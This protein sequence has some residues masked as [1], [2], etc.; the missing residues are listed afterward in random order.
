MALV[1][2]VLV[3]DAV[4]L[5]PLLL[6][7]HNYRGSKQRNN[8]AENNQQAANKAVIPSDA[9]NSDKVGDIGHQTDETD[10]EK[11]KVNRQL[12]QYTKQLSKFTFWLV[13]VTLALGAVALWQG[14]LA[15]REFITAHRP[16]MVVRRFVLTMDERTNTPIVEFIVANDGFTN[17]YI[18][19]HNLSARALTPEDRAAFERHSFPEYLPAEPLLRKVYTPTKRLAHSV[20]IK[21]FQDSTAVFVGIQSGRVTLICY[22]FIRYN[23]S[24]GGSYE[25]KFYRTYEPG[26]KFLIPSPDPDYDDADERERQHAQTDA[27]ESG[28]SAIG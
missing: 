20:R 25:T 11:L 3:I 24:M 5:E 7:Q 21:G 27:D 16:Q 18:G 14:W 15:R 23:D 6:D 13:M 1:V 19:D 8:K 17:A 4:I 2:S 22:G 12:L 10:S 26:K 9:P 28:L